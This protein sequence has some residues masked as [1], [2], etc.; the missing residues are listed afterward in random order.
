VLTVN[1]DEEDWSSCAESI[2]DG[3]GSGRAI[4]R[5]D[6]DKYPL[7][8]VKHLKRRMADRFLPHQNKLAQRRYERKRSALKALNAKGCASN[9]SKQL[10]KRVGRH[11]RDWNGADEKMFRHMVSLE[12]QL[13][14][15]L[16]KDRA[17]LAA[18]E[19][20]S[21]RKRKRDKYNDWTS[22][23]SSDTSSGSDEDE[24]LI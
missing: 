10:L 11:L 7:S 23:T 9:K 24:E 8:G 14:H 20:A 15:S 13:I 12:L 18:K 16:A 1:E 6:F 22:D 2:G 3:D 5:H 19:R 4:F 21:S 17:E